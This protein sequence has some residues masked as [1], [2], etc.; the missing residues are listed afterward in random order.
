MA[1][2]R[3]EQRPGPIHLEAALINLRDFPIGRF[4]RGESVHNEEA[5]HFRPV[6]AEI[7]GLT[8]VGVVW[9]WL[10]VRLPSVAR[11]PANI[12]A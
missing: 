9:L 11:S 7:L 10:R 8:L 1:E 5:R 6:V 2:P 4:R 3:L 12:V